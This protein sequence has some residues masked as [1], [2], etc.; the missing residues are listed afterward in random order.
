MCLRA[1]GQVICCFYHLF[2]STVFRRETLFIQDIEYRVC[3]AT[4]AYSIGIDRRVFVRE[5]SIATLAA[6]AFCSFVFDCTIPNATFWHGHITN[7]TLKAIIT[8]SHIPMPI[9]V[10]PTPVFAPSMNR[11]S[12]RYP[13]REASM[14]PV[15]RVESAAHRNQKSALGAITFATAGFC[16]SGI[17]GIAGIWT[18]LKYHSSPIHITPLA[19]WNHLKR[20]VMYCGVSPPISPRYARLIANKT[21]SMNPAVIVLLRLESIA[22]IFFS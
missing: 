13:F 1:F 15:T 22:L 8:P 14:T 10:C 17:L 19:T 12:M 7:Q 5:N 18:K 11:A 16:S 2:L 20:N 9:A 6:L 4:I 3:A 21:R